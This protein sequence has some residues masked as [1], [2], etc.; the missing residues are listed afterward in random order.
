V[1]EEQTCN[2]R[3]SASRVS[4]S[5]CVCGQG[6]SC[7]SLTNQTVMEMSVANCGL[8]MVG[9]AAALCVASVRALGL[10]LAQQHRAGATLMSELGPAP[11]TSRLSL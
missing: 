5:V 7:F 9:L 4:V 11:G 3:P 1:V 10:G 6:W 2:R 8:V